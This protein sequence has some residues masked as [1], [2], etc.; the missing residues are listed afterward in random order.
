MP[1]TTLGA[2]TQRLPHLGVSSANI[3]SLLSHQMSRRLKVRRKFG[4]LGKVCMRL[5]VGHGPGVPTLR[6]A[7]HL[8]AT[9]PTSPTNTRHVGS[10]P[11]FRTSPSR[12][13]RIRKYHPCVY[14]GS[15]Q[16]SAPNLA[17][18]GNSGPLKSFRFV[19]KAHSV[20][21]LLSS[22]V[23][24]KQDATDRGLFGGCK[25]CRAEDGR[26]GRHRCR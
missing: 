4:A 23:C 8:R 9:G 3:E 25:A 5:L 17:V 22:I 18:R 1:G 21:P 2:M 11:R 14:W 12:T 26:H 15:L 19:R 24:L 10:V 20:R 6:A 7:S 13:G 16:I